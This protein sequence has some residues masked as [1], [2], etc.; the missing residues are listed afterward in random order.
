MNF[1]LRLETFMSTQTLNWR[2]YVGQKIT[3]KHSCQ[4]SPILRDPPAKIRTGKKLPHISRMSE[5]IAESG[6]YSRRISQNN[7]EC[8]RIPDAKFTLTKIFII[9]TRLHLSARFLRQIN[10]E[11]TKNYVPVLNR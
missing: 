7:A 6:E 3:F 2:P 1:L 4:T 8:R 10:E 5:N 9:C 11:V